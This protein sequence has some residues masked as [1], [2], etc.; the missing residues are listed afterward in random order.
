MDSVLVFREFSIEKKMWKKIKSVKSKFFILLFFF[1]IYSQL[2]RAG[3]VVCNSVFHWLSGDPVSY[4]VC[5]LFL[6]SVSGRQNEAQSA[7]VGSTEQSGESLGKERDE[8]IK[9]IIFLL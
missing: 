4:N 7:A 3:Q 8:I 2:E 5:Q 6:D 1:Q 9:G